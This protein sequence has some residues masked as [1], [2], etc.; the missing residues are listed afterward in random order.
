MRA[1]GYLRV[2]TLDQEYG[3]EVQ[4][5]LIEAEAERRG[6]EVVAWETDRGRTGKKIK[7]PGL[8]AA[9]E[10]L[11]RGDADLLVV[12]KLDRLSR[13][14]PDFTSLIRE[15]THP[16]AARRRGAWSSS[17]PAST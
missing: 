17:I 4:R 14:V 1:V 7:R 3:I 9:R 12:S 5:A 16:P 15:A 2:S 8:D 6:W 10:R 11:T 13:S